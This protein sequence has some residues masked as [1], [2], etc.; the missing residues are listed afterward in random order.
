MQQNNI[1]SFRVYFIGLPPWASIVSP[2]LC[3]LILVNSLSRAVILQT[4]A[5]SPHLTT[6]QNQMGPEGFE[7]STNGL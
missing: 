6:A 1:V 2:L 7:P 3:Y 4:F 5:W